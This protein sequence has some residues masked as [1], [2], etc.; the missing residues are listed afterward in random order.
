MKM[1]ELA[2]EETG[3]TRKK[4]AEITGK[5]FEI[6]WAKSNGNELLKQH[7]ISISSQHLRKRFGIAK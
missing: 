1:C 2:L 4:G 7:K 3:L 5:E 6:E